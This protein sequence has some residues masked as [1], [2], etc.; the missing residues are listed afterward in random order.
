MGP[1][2]VGKNDAR[3][4]AGFKSFCIAAVTLSEI[5]LATGFESGSSPSVHDFA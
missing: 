3:E 1:I 5:Q 2:S 4:I